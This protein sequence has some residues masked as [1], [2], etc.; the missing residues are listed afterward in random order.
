MSLMMQIFDIINQ[1]ISDYKVKKVKRV[2]LKVGK[3][4]NVMPDSLS[5]CFEVLS[6]GTKCEGAELVI[7]E[8]P[9]TG[10]CLDCQKEFTSEGFPLAC[11]NC[12]SRNTR[13]IGGTELAIESIE[14]E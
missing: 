4:S 9:L 5:F 6:E 12:G 13:M 8:T 10:R 1:T 14:A 3:M 7:Q 2:T 11:P